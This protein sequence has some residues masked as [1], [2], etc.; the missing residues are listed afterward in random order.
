MALPV[1]LVLANT[2]FL[3]GQAGPASSHTEP[4]TALSRGTHIASMPSISAVASVR[5]ESSSRLPWACALL[6]GACLIQRIPTLQG[7]RAQRGQPCVIACRAMTQR[8]KAAPSVQLYMQSSVAV[9]CCS[10]ATATM[11]AQTSKSLTSND[12]A[13]RLHLRSECPTT[14]VARGAS[15]SARLAGTAV[16]AGRARHA[17]RRQGATQS[18]TKQKA[19]RAGHRRVGARLNATHRCAEA[20]ALPEPSFDSSRQRTKLQFGLQAARNARRELVRPVVSAARAHGSAGS[21][22]RTIRVHGAYKDKNTS[23]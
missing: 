21:N 4:R 16:W 15:S 22:T 10:N 19:A 17:V 6:F 9:G 14:D 18:S 8:D 7:R 20:A 23:Y 1:Q 11:H 13:P 2:A 3:W 12:T 5:S